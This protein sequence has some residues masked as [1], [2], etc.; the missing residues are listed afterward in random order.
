MPLWL[1][2]MLGCVPPC[3]EV[4][5]VYSL[6]FPRLACISVFERDVTMLHVPRGHPA[7]SYMYIYIYIYKYIYRERD[8]ERERYMKC[9]I[10]G[11]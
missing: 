10:I 2:L 5:Y 6:L 11:I 9:L 1:W 7:V 4:E 3:N 8:R